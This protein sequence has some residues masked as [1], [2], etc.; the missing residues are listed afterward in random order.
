MLA[1]LFST[2]G[3]FFEEASSSIIKYETENKKESVYSAGFINMLF[4]VIILGIIAFVRGSF[5]FNFASLPT[6]ITRIFLEIAQMQMTFLAIM[7]NDRSTFTFVRNLTIPLLLIVDIAIGFTISSTQWAGI[8]IILSVIG[9]VLYFHIINLKGVGYSLFTAV[10]AVATISLYKY[11]ITNFNS[12]EAEQI[13]V[14]TILALYFFGMAIFWRK[15]N[16]FN[17]LKERVFFAHGFSQGISSIFHSF[18]LAFG[19]PG[20]VISAKRASGVLMGTIFGHNYF[21]E[22]KFGTK[23]V[24]GV[25][26]IIGLVFLAI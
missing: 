18:A 6:F 17:L 8:L 23:L 10:N 1:V 19:T 25:I 24:M 21:S 4:S 16:P 12:V 13:I 3:S 26:I 7:K 11:N 5:I 14:L 22:R 9:V 15:E 20:V 2:I